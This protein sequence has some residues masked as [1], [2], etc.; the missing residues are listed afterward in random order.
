MEEPRHVEIQIMADKQGNVVY[1]GERDCSIQRRHQKLVEE[2][3]SPA[4]DRELREQMGAAAVSIGGQSGELSWCRDGGV[5][6]R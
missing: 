2:A 3:P 6:I 4:L 1:L 5:S